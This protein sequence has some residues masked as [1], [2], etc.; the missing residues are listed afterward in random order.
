MGIAVKEATAADAALLSRLATE[1]FYE[2]YS[3]YNTPENMRDYTQ[4]HFN[5]TRTLEE[6]NEQGT[7]FI[8]AFAGDEPVGYTKMRS[9]ENPPELKG[10]KHIEI[11]RIYVSKKMQGHKIG[12]ALMNKC[13]DMARAQKLDVIWLGVWEKNT[14]ALAFYR[15]V[16][17]V[18]FGD[19]IFMLGHDEQLDHLLKLDLQ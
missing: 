6:L 14:R 4:T 10:K 18:N 5:E 13:I 11:E 3:W 9:T 12:F 17:F 15:Q 19:H 7:Y 1:T 16:G 8:I 2:T